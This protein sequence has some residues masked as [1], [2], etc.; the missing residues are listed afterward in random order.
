MSHN[1]R[2]YARLLR[3]RGY[4]V[5]PQRR[6]ILDAIC[7]AG[8]HATLEEILARLSAGPTPISRAT[9]YRALDFLTHNGLVAAVPRAD[10]KTVY[11]IS[12]AEPHHHL[13]CQACGREL[14]IGHAEVEALFAALQL[15][16]GFTPSAEHL[17]LHGLCAA[18][19]ESAE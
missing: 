6:A 3:L 8:Q 2:D 7:S 17:T 14:Q 18:C 19:A 11:E 15:R 9:L 10:G 16:Y 4:R 1:T 5:T 12:A 13:V